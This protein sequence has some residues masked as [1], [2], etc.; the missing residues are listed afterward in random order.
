MTTPSPEPRATRRRED[1][2]T[3][4]EPAARDWRRAVPTEPKSRN[5]LVAVV[6]GLVA[7]ATLVLTAVGLVWL[8]GG[9]LR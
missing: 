9:L 8:F 6:V 1:A 2:A 5:D 4:A 7:T 3:G